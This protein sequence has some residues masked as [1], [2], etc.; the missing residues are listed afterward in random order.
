M[1]QMIILLLFNKSSS[2]TVEQIENETEITGELLI[3]T[4]LSLLENR[5]LTCPRINNKDFTK[6]NI[7]SNDIIQISNDFQK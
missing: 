5:L 6:I 2:W 3:K 1:Y 7:D 4:I